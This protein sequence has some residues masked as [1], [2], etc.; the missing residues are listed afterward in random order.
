M[1]DLGEQ[2]KVLEASVEMRLQLKPN[3]LSKVGVVDVRI[4]PEEPSEN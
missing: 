4:N 3:H 2:D 1:T